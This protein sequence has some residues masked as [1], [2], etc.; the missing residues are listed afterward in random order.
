MFLT[1]GL[2]ILIIATASRATTCGYKDGNPQSARTAQSDYRCRVDTANGL[3]GFCPA[4]VISARDCGL[5]GVCVDRHSCTD[6]C[7][8]LSDRPDIT[9]FSCESSQ[10]CST[11][12]LI[13]G[14]DQSFEYI[15]CGAE[16]RTDRLFPS[17]S[18]VAATT[19]PSSFSSVLSSSLTSLPSRPTTTVVETSPIPTS[20]SSSALNSSIASSTP[21]PISTT[22]KQEP[23]HLGAIVGGA[24][25][26]LIV[27][28][29]TVLGVVLIRRKHG[30]KGQG[31]SPPGHTNHGWNEFAD[32][33]SGDVKKNNHWVSNH[34]PVEMYSGHHVNMEPVELDTL[35]RAK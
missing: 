32:D 2:L 9:T 5:A 33:A 25:G 12:L 7:G 18:S 4:T 6:G 19:T 15:A 10:F 1:I 29:L 28:C 21:E 14:P 30:L 34:G 11:V 3:W 22:A 24:I 26:G 27:I 16:A 35:K 23:L 20:S 17:P 8:R 31:T 13:N